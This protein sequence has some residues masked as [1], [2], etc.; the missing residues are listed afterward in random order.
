M[1]YIKRKKENLILHYDPA[2]EP[3]ATVDPG[4]IF[5]VET[6]DAEEWVKDIQTDQDVIPEDFNEDF[7][8]PA[9]GPIYVNGAEKGDTVVVEFL[10]IDV[11]PPSFTC[12]LKGIGYT[13]ELFEN[14]PTT[15][16]YE[17]KNQFLYF[18]EEIRFPLAPMAGIVGTTPKERY[19]VFLVGDHG[20]NVDDPESSPG[21][22]I[23]LPVFH[24]GGLLAFGDVHAAQGKGETLMGVETDA[25]LTLRVH[26]LKNFQVEGM[27]IETQNKWAFIATGDEF[28]ETIKL[29][30][31]RM[32][33][34]L[35]E[36]LDLSIEEATAVMCAK[37]NYGINSALGKDYFAVIR[38]E[39]AKDIDAKDR[40]SGAYERNGN[41]FIGGA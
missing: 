26:L 30:A 15:H 21:S 36:R 2:K 6:A 29:A 8:T 3:I 35:Q 32:A 40:L 24:E 39:I 34:F 27:R 5:Q 38:A 7:V 33:R 41:I 12:T 14:A 19:R 10:S 31:H 22:Y 9:T 13:N 18:N 1:Q 20:G 11:V 28:S 23:Y 17:I 16:V 25:V 37:C 4:E